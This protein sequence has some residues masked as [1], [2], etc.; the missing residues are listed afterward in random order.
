MPFY[1][2]DVR[3]LRLSLGLDYDEFARVIGVSSRTV[4]RWESN[5]KQKRIPGSAGDI[6]S[7][8][9]IAVDK[10]CDKFSSLVREASVMGGLA[11]LLMKLLKHYLGS[12][13]NPYDV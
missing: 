1:S 3:K 11:F 5:S 4:R 6:L 2:K 7:V 12:D 10:D 13:F 9:Q 8:F